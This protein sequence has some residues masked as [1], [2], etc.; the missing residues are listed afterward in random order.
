MLPPE[1]GFSKEKPATLYHLRITTPDGTELFKLGITNR[2]PL[3]RIAGMG[4]QA[5]VVVDVL[6]SIVFDKGRDAR[7]AEKRLHRKFSSFRYVGPRLMKN[8]NTELFT[9]KLL[10]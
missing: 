7:I 5:G 2:D 8:G 10:D 4:V 6:D 9:V 3:A 1:Y